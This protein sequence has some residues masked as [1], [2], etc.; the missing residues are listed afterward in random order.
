M[1]I[2]YTLFI[3]SRKI[4]KNQISLKSVQWELSCSVR[5]DRQTDRY[6]ES[7]SRF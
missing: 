7:N 1:Y 4:L 3:Y 5:A 2:G 6:D